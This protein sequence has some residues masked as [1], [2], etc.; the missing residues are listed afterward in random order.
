MSID[1]QGAVQ[2]EARYPE[3]KRAA[4]RMIDGFL[5]KANANI[6]EMVTTYGFSSWR[7]IDKGEIVQLDLDWRWSFPT[8]KDKQSED[9]IAFEEII[10]ASKELESQFDVFVFNGMGCVGYTIDSALQSLLPDFVVYESDPVGIGPYDFDEK[11]GALEDFITAEKMMVETLWP[12]QTL[13]LDDDLYQIDDVTTVRIAT[14]EEIIFALSNG[15]IGALETKHV[16]RKSRERQA[17]ISRKAEVPKIPKESDPVFMRLRRENKNFI[18]N[19]QAVW[20]TLGNSE[21]GVSAHMTRTPLGVWSPTF[22]NAIPTGLLFRD[23]VF[24][25]ARLLD[26]FKRVWLMVKDGDRVDPALQ[27]SMRRL[28]FADKRDRIEDQVLDLVIAAEALYLSDSGDKQELN[29]R[30]SLRAAIWLDPDTNRV[31]RRRAFDLLKAA[32]GLRSA[33]AHGRSP[34]LETIKVGKEKIPL[35]KALDELRQIVQGGILKALDHSINAGNGKFDP[36]WEELLFNLLETERETP[37][38]LQTLAQSDPSS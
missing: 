32:Y 17:L 3:L 37:E 5:E 12:V 29:F 15:L 13:W 28:S 30:A 33:V 19:F 25:E 18:E 7:R 24:A 4:K 35:Q 34:S 1:P 20:S 38:W 27:L 8:E 26:G 10:R 16:L 11:Y 14:D 31:T 23:P 21:L 2:R 9:Y 36:H 22:N 6:A